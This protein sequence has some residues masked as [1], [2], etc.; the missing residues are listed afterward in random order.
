MAVSVNQSNGD[1]A[2]VHEINVTPFI[3]VILVLLIIF[4]VAAPL[5]TVDIAVDLPASNAQPQPRP[6]KPVYLTVKP[7]LSLS[8]GNETVGRAALPG[9]LDASTNG[10]KDSRIFLRADKLVPYGEVMQVMNML[11]AAGY[12]K[13]A[14]VGLEQ[15]S[16]P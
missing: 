3:D 11:R 2:E 5:A 16:S 7:D 10:H 4:M 9:V 15:A 14:L 8:V 6:D 1:L 13:V 12:L